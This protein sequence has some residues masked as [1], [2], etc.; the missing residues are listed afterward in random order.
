MVHIKGISLSCVQPNSAEREDDSLKARSQPT[1]DRTLC[2]STPEQSHHAFA[3]SKTLVRALFL[4]APPFLPSS[5]LVPFP[6]LPPSLRPLP[7]PSTWPT[8][9]LPLGRLHRGIDNQK[10]SASHYRPYLRYPS[11]FAVHLLAPCLIL[12]TVSSL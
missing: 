1:T 5:S 11:V 3:S 2:R 7:S 10:H 4:R 8:T 12:S 9:S 6:S